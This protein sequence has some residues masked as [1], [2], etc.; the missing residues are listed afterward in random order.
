MTWACSGLQHSYTFLLLTLQGSFII[1]LCGDLLVHL[2]FQMTGAIWLEG[3]VSCSRLDRSLSC[4]LDACSTWGEWGEVTW[5]ISWNGTLWCHW[6]FTSQSKSPFI[7]TTTSFV[8]IFKLGLSLFRKD[9]LD[10]DCLGQKPM[11]LHF[12]M[13]PDSV[14]EY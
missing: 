1:W 5:C 10:L 11:H 6:K 14:F 9:I 12:K 13:N 3:L 8:N 2:F 7:S 4:V